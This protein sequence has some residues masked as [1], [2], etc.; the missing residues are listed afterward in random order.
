MASEDNFQDLERHVLQLEANVKELKST[1]E[2][3]RT[4]DAEYEALKEDVSA[5]SQDGAS[6]AA[7]LSRVRAEFEGD[8][9]KGK[10]MA[11]IFGEG[12]SA[13]QVLGVLGRRLDYV[14]TNVRT[15]EKRV[16]QAEMAVD[17]ARV[18]TDSGADEEELPITE[19]FES[20]DEEGNVLSHEIW[21]PGS[22]QAQVDKIMEK[23]AVANGSV[24]KAE[25]E[26][27]LDASPDE[28]KNRDE[29]R[30]PAKSPPAPKA[31]PAASTR[32]DSPPTIPKE[33]K[34]V[35]TQVEVD[36]QP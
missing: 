27:V 28:S 34:K 7:G 20:L 23:A 24:V 19:I 18:V 10:D 35:K 2:H 29:K 36:E 8:L 31:K 32:K 3:W 17:A 26:E 21:T 4:W 13:S 16:E 5:A 22:K 12:R 1:L 25:V 33:D 9:V 15:L 11:E 14:G 30:L 6:E